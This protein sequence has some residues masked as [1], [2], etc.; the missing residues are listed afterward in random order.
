[1]SELYATKIPWEIFWNSYTQI[2]LECDVRDFINLKNESKVYEF[3]AAA[4]ARFEQLFSAS[5]VANAIDINYKNVKSCISALQTSGMVRLL[6]LFS[7][8][9]G[10]SFTKTT[11]L[12][13]IDTGL[14]YQLIRWTTSDQLGA[15]LW[16]VLC[17]KRLWF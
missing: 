4:A 3:F 8:N 9:I 14:V 1:M 5:D 17:L 10:K 16:R 11:K 13:F 7:P 2:Y 15:V 6:G 12:Y